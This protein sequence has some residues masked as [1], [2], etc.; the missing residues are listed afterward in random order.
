MTADYHDKRGAADSARVVFRTASDATVWI[1]PHR[2]SE[3]ELLTVD[4]LANHDSGTIEGDV[5]FMTF[6]GNSSHFFNL[7]GSPLTAH[8]VEIEK[9]SLPDAGRTRS[10]PAA[11]PIDP[12][13]ADYGSCNGDRTTQPN[14]WGNY[15]CVCD[16]TIDRVIA[17]QT[18]E[19]IEL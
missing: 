4:F 9:V 11:I 8:C 16:N 18:V 12:Q 6:A 1:N 19:E 15:T 2:I 10:N 13:F 14:G 5:G 7:F 17:H 3:N